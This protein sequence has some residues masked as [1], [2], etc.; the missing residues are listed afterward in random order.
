MT[1]GQLG[2]IG[3]LI[4]ALIAV[5][6]AAWS[7]Y[8]LDQHR[9]KQNTRFEIYQRLLALN[10]RYFWVASRTLHNELPDAKILDECYR[11]SWEI[12]DRV[13]AFDKL[14]HLGELVE[15]LFSFE[16]ASANERANRLG[17]LIDRYSTLV[18]P[19]FAAKMAKVSRANVIALGNR[20][21]PNSYAPGQVPPLEVTIASLR[22]AQEQ[23]EGD[24]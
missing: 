13:R 9:R 15:V 6:G 5:I 8:L 7:Q 20:K 1:D 12:A 19:A 21:D 11:L 3:A 17:A 4:G 10:E 18:N 22:A 24:A 14:E 16:I 23:I 2:F